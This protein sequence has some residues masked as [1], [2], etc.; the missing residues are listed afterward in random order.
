MNPAKKPKSD[1]IYLQHILECTAL[2]RDYTSGGKDEFMRNVLHQDGVM[3]RLQTMAESTQRLSNEAKTKAPSA[4][5][6]APS[7]DW[8]VIAGFRNLLVHDYMNGIDLNQIWNIIES[9][10]PELET[11]AQALLKSIEIE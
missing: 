10:L 1:R 2:I 3:R 9:Y 6:K 4:K 11:E 7:V 5:T 8:R